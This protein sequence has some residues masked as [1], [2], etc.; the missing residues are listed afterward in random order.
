MINPTEHN[1]SNLNKYQCQQPFAVKRI[2]AFT[3]KVMQMVSHTRHSRILNLGCG[4]GYDI[5]NLFE[6]RQIEFNLCCGLDLNIKA[7]KYSRKIVSAF[8]LDVVN[9]DVHHLPFKLNGFDL[10]LCLEVLEHL[11]NPESVLEKI[12]RSFKGACLFSTPYEP[13]YRLTRML[14]LRKNIRNFGNHPEHVNHWS[15]R[16]FRRLLEKYFEV[17]AVEKSFPWT[18]ALCRVGGKE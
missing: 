15:A 1:S 16:G 11:M 14:L 3:S 10:I 7:L 6:K 18:I 17:E 12:S 5:K 4:E 2:D 8:R 13:L 9:G